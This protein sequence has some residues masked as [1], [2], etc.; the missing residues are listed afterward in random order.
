MF[1]RVFSILG[2]KNEELGDDQKIWKA[3]CVFQG[4]NVRTKTGTSAADLFVEGSNAPASFAATRA[5]IG[6]AALRG[7]N[8]S[9]RDAETAYLQ[10]VIDT[11]TRT[12]TFVELPR[13]WWPDSWFHDGALRQIPKYDRPH[14]RLLR[15]LY[16]HPEAGAL[17]E[18]R[19]DSIM[20]TL[21]WSPTP[22]NGKVYSHTRT[23][24]AM[25][26]Y[27][28]DMLLLSPPNDTDRLR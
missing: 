28:D 9:L 16:G 11:P 26:V 22:G 6:V 21:G 10:A 24:A 1:G 17:W 8:A 2:I 23:G 5:A 15:A 7:F 20:K 12:P 25:V 18:A 27:V 4:S 14:C 19:L 13:E 3:R